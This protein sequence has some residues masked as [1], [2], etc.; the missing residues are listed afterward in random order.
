MVLVMLEDDVDRKRRNPGLSIDYSTTHGVIQEEVL[1]C[2][3]S[4]KH[5]W[6]QPV[7]GT[8]QN[9]TIT[10]HHQ[11]NLARENKDQAFWLS[12]TNRRHTTMKRIILAS[13]LSAE[14][15]K[16]PCSGKH[17]DQDWT[18]EH[19]QQNGEENLNRTSGY[20]RLSDKYLNEGWRWTSRIRLNRAQ[21]SS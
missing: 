6:L 5:Q 1:I 21:I 18:D 17:R 14:A 19:V 13:L 9:L 8:K 7:C 16:L 12:T 4:E 15:A 3:K 20:V 11:A 2:H 10:T